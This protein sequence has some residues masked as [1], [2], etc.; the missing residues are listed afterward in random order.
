M[1]KTERREYGSDH[2]VVS[3]WEKV[4][5]E[6]DVKEDHLETISPINH[7]D[8]IKIPILLIHGE[9]DDVVKFRQSRNMASE[10]EDAD[11]AFEFIE[12]EEG[13]HY[14]STAKNRMKAMLAIDQFLKKH[15]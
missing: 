14:L 11:K 5:S 1:M 2:W 13:D 7:V 4:I 15:L 8:K 12:L 9:R 6:G 3:Y 10:L